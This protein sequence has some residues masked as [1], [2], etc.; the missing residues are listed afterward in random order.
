MLI[1]PGPAKYLLIPDAF[2]RRPPRCE[3][4]V[5]FERGLGWQ[6]WRAIL[7]DHKMVTWSRLLSFPF[8]SGFLYIPRG[9]LWGIIKK[10]RKKGE[11]GWGRSKEMEEVGGTT[12]FL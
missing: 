11:Q 9:D 2:A 10:R 8:D 4:N 5:T 1:I 12:E 7:R 3:R 6:H